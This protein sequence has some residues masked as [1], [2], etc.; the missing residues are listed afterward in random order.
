MLGG[1]PWAARLDHH[2]IPMKR[3]IGTCFPKK[4]KLNQEQHG[5]TNRMHHKH[6]RNFLCVASAYIEAAKD[7]T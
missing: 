2:N 3:N 1:L 4:K 7:M 6:K 5:P